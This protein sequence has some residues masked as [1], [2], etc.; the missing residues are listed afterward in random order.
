MST[1]AFSVFAFLFIGTFFGMGIIYLVEVL[2]VRSYV[3]Q[4]IRANK[5]LDVV[6]VPTP[7]GV[8]LVHVKK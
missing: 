7:H 2:A 8:L 3:R 6:E 5:G 4:V 1:I